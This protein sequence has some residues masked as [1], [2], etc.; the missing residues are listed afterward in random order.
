MLLAGRRFSGLVLMSAIVLVIS[1]ALE[2][3]VFSV[4]GFD[5]GLFAASLLV[6][7]ILLG[8]DSLIWFAVFR[9]RE[10]RGVG[11]EG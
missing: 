7:A 1:W 11:L 10:T 8:G 5:A 6:T 2:I 4:A 9:H 3:Y